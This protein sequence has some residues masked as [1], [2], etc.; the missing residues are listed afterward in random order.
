M[1]F[2]VPE[3]FRITKGRMGSAPE[4]GNNGAFQFRLRGGET[5]FA[6][7]SDGEGWE[8]V[9]VTFVGGIGTPRWKQMCEIK[10]IFWDAEDCVVQYHPP[11]SEY[12]NN[13]PTCL[14]LWRP[15]GIE[16][17]RPPV[18]LVGIT[19]KEMSW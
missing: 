9:R 7:A 11:K 10:D 3:R 4:A 19:R 16:I 18:A 5:V 12:I 1:A 14:H 17:P 8:H 15:I 2:H 13:C 6:V